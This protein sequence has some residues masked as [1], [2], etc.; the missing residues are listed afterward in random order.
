MKESKKLT[1]V[2]CETL[3]SIIFQLSFSDARIPENPS[4]RPKLHV[5][6]VADLQTLHH[7]PFRWTLDCYYYDVIYVLWTL[8]LQ[9]GFC[10]C[11]I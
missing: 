3:A 7:Y 1:I 11:R 2:L 4:D 10:V 8:N 6:F 5:V 9:M